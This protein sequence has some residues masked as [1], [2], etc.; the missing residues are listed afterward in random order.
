MKTKTTVIVLLLLLTPFVAFAGGE[1]DAGVSGDGVAV[2][3][4]G[5][6]P[7]VE[8]V[9]EMEVFL[10]G[11]TLVDDFQDNAYTQYVLEKTNIQMLIDVTPSAEAQQV[12]NVMLASGD[13]PGVFISHGF[14]PAQQVL[15]GGQGVLL[16][17]N[18]LIDEY[19]VNVNR[20][21]ETF[22]LVRQ[23]FV[24]PDGN[25]YTLPDINDCFHCSMAQK[26]WVYQPWLDTLGLDKP[27]TTDELKEMLIAFRDGDPNGNGLQD[28]IP[29]AGA[30]QGWFAGIDGF[31]MNSFIYT[32]GNLAAP[33]DTRLYIEN[34]QIVASFDKPEWR[35]GLQFINDLYSEGLIAPDSFVQDQ[36]QYRQMGENPETVILGSGT[37]GHMGVF[38]DFQGESG[39]WGD[40]VTIPPLEGPNG[41][42]YARYNP[43]FGN[44]EWAI[45]NV[46][47]NAAAAFRLG[48][49]WYDFD[50]MQRNLYGREGIE[51]RMPEAGEFGINGKEATWVPIVGRGL[52]D[53]QSWWNQAGPHL[54]TR[55]YRLGRYQPDPTALEVVLFEQTRDDYEPF[56][57]DG[58]AIVPPLSF[59]SSVAAEVTEIQTTMNDYVREMIARFI[60]GDANINSDAEWNNYLAELDAIGLDRYLEIM[61]ETYDAR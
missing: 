19:G 56:Q 23:N 37:A 48:D 55:D 31:L 35:Q 47:E 16:P 27:Q 21:F 12:V 32:H 5:T 46:E 30:I 54:R 38:A 25:I 29:L 3:P 43:T 13:Y 20:A 34:G 18:D 44:P 40:Y 51:W 17:L 36:A 50:M 33:N 26:L 57:Q 61:Q 7:I 60:T 53:R 41:V 45:T 10:S 22:P 9:L 14:T 58:A 1:A 11:T 42:R 24:M 59:D 8:E 39:R 6:F 4:A 52:I 49:A 28:E 2:T 15:Y